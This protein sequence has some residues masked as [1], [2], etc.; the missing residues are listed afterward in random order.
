MIKDSEIKGIQSIDLEE[1]KRHRLDMFKK[2][3]EIAKEEI[4]S[5]FF[6][7]RKEKTNE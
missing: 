7:I 2:A 4:S 1:T 5:D 6:E 3:Q